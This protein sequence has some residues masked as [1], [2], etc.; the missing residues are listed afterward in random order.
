MPD[1]TFLVNR[2][3]PLRPSFVPEELCVCHFSFCADLTEEKRMLC[4][5]AAQAAGRLFEYGKSF[6]HHFYGISGYRS[7]KTQESLYQKRVRISSEAEADLYVARPGCSEHQTGLALDV[8]APSAGLA[9]EEFFSDTPEGKWLSVYAPM[10]GF[11][12]R[13]PRGKES[14][15]GYAYEPWHIRYVGRSLSLYL[16]LTGLTLEE[17]YRLSE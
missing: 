8:S 9:L 17:Y 13:Y 2:T 1:F 10:F 7:Y 11:I 16:S 4:S 15:T 3:H 12:I 6:G 5:T 14:V